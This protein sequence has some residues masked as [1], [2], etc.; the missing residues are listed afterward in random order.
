MKKRN[1]ILCIILMLLCLAGGIS[2]GLMMP[3]E[4]EVDKNDK[5]CVDKNVSNND[6]VENYEIEVECCYDVFEDIGVPTLT[7]SEFYAEKCNNSN[8][9]CHKN[10]DK[11]KALNIISKYRHNQN[12]DKYYN[13]MFHITEDLKNDI[14]ASNLTGTKVLCQDY[15]GIDGGNCY[16][17]DEIK[18]VSYYEL[19]KKKKEL[20]GED[21]TL[22]KK[23]FFTYPIG[24]F[25]YFSNIN[26]F[27]FK[28]YEPKGGSATKSINVVSTRETEEKLFVTISE[29]GYYDGYP[30]TYEDLYAYTFKKE[31]NNYYLEEITRLKS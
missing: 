5:Q 2:M 6:K 30:D 24:S 27:V 25:S 4:K 13:Q 8:D 10:F 7:I 12:N 1:I 17:D 3:S 11:T 9:V 29:F 22:E 18:I 14:A 15:F 31:N 23:G 19:L 26:S 20:F 28:G 21:S 16:E